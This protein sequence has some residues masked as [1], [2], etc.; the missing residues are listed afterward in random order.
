METLRIVFLLPIVLRFTRNDRDPAGCTD[1]F[2]ANE[3]DGR[4]RMIRL[5]ASFGTTANAFP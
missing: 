1:L 2:G 5:G 3:E 4:V